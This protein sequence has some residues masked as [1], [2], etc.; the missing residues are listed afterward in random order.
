MSHSVS[1]AV[2]P[3]RNWPWV[4]AVFVVVAL[5]VV[6]ASMLSSA[7][8]DKPGPSAVSSSAP[9]TTELPSPT[10]TAGTAKPSSS[11][12][13]TEKPLSDA[14]IATIKK[15]IESHTPTDLYDY[16][17][18]PVHIQFAASD[19]NDDRTPDLAMTDLDHIRQ[20]SDWNWKLDSATLATFTAGSYGNNFSD[21]AIIGESAETYVIALRVTDGKISSIFVSRSAALLTAPAATPTST[22]TP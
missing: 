19:F 11:A 3:R 9:P 2:R 15:A 5:I 22:P 10:P 13:P 4:V 16:L 20:T 21:D 14:D 6:G 17:A 7:L 8:A 18:D 1:N 12:T